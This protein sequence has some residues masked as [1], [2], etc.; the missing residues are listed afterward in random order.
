MDGGADAER[1]VRSTVDRG[2]CIKGY[3]GGGQMLRGA[4]GQT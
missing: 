3:N 2:I 4:E 1:S